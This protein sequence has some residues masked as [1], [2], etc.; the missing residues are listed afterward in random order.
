MKLSR[1]GKMLAIAASISGILAA[2]FKVRKSL[3]GKNDQSG[4]PRGPGKLSISDWKRALSETKNA[5]GSKNLSVLSAGV[6]FYST[7]A[8]FPLLAAAVAIAA[9][10]I[11]T[12]QLQSLASATE[13][14]LPGDVSGV[15]T[16]QLERLVSRRADNLF[17]AIVA[18]GLALF[19]A[20]GAS[21]TLVT[22]SNVA[23][24]VKETRSWLAQQAW[25]I[26]WTL[27]GIG[28]GFIVVGLLAVNQDALE[29]FGFSAQIASLL[30]YGRWPMIMLLLIFGLAVFYRY[31]P[32]RSNARWQWV[33][34][35]AVIA[36]VV[37]LIATALFFAYVRSF[38]AYNQ[39]YS[40]FAGIVILMVWLNLSALIV[41]LG[42]EVNHRLEAVGREKFE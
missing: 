36:T 21:K 26:V 27:G 41:L 38:G 9:L 20:S 42:A 1:E 12:D 28:F 30:L 22:A 11:T 5:L 16:E 6:A 25:G 32:N 13:S 23:Y 15:V 34:W 14:Y 17:A 7:L 8:F 24:G 39:S 4:I 3:G 18:I 29:Y 35:G 2:A 19:G 40:L 10:V 37:W 31:G 33:S